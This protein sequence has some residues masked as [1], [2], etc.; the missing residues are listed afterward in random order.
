MLQNDKVVQY[1]VKEKDFLPQHDLDV[2]Y[3][4]DAKFLTKSLLSN[5]LL[6]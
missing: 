4:I 3:G 5:M 1:Q 6:Q 2:L